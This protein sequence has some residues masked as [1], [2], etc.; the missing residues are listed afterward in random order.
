MSA[1]EQ[2][3]EMPQVWACNDTASLPLLDLVNCVG[4]EHYPA[5]LRIRLMSAGRLGSVCCQEQRHYTRTH[6]SIHAVPR[7]MRLRVTW[8]VK[9]RVAIAAWTGRGS[10]WCTMSND[11]ATPNSST[12][13]SDPT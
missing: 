10:S 11:V 13:G 6:K 1:A 4:H 3:C 12:M 5:R 7:G 9:R 8:R 2:Q